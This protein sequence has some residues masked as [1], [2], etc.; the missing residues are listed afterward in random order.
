MSKQVA[1]QSRN[2]NKGMHY[3]NATGM[4]KTVS[5]LR[6]VFPNCLRV[7]HML[8]SAGY[9][10]HLPYKLLPGLHQ[11]TTGEYLHGTRTASN[12]LFH[13]R[14]CSPCQHLTAVL[15]VLLLGRWRQPHHC[16]CPALRH[17]WPTIRRARARCVHGVRCASPTLMHTEQPSGCFEGWNSPK[18]VHRRQVPT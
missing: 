15:V 18:G 8:S 10:I 11:H 13:H 17:C 2:W 6:N 4:L 12:I 7:S 1:G 3:S 5:E 14:P 9:Q 16:P